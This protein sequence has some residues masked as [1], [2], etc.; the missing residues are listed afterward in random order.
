MSQIEKAKQLTHDL[1]EVK[2]VTKSFFENNKELLFKEGLPF[3]IV[4]FFELKSM[5]ETLSTITYWLDDKKLSTR[6]HTTVESY[7]T[8]RSYHDLSILEYLELLN[9]NVDKIL[10]Y[11]AN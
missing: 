3:I 6:T 1:S 4:D 10:P 5:H 2:Y 7:A 11:A 8:D 9:S